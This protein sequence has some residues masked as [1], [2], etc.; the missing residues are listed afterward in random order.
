VRV[1]IVAFLVLFLA[2]P[3]AANVVAYGPN[4][5]GTKTINTAYG[6]GSNALFVTVVARG[7]Q[8]VDITFQVAP[9]LGAFLELAVCRPPQNGA[10]CTVAGHVPPSWSYKVGAPAS[11][12][13]SFWYELEDIMI[14]IEV[15]LASLWVLSFIGGVLVGRW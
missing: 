14:P 4:Q 13:L 5:V 7:N 12:S 11:V 2:A 6:N 10:S 3:A 9:P 15:A 1:V 8:N